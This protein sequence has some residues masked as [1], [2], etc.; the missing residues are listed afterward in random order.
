MKCVVNIQRCSTEKLVIVSTLP[1]ADSIAE[2]HD[3]ISVKVAGIQLHITI[4]HMH[5][6]LL[7]LGM[8]QPGSRHAQ[9]IQFIGAT[10]AFK[11][12]AVVSCLAVRASDLLLYYIF[13]IQCRI[14]TLLGNWD[15]FS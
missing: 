10:F 15:I 13:F 9:K 5:Q 12:I 7:V 14:P 4:A 1:Q 6:S 3:L 8:Q 11:L 2:L